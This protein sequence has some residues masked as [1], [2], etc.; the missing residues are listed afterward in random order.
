MRGVAKL[1]LEMAEHD[2]WMYTWSLSKSC[3]SSEG[4]ISPSCWTSGNFIG[5]FIFDIFL[6]RQENKIN[7]FANICIYISFNE[8]FVKIIVNIET[9]W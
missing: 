1:E 7:A 2:E 8:D 6:V 5:N 4:I 9:A 3:F